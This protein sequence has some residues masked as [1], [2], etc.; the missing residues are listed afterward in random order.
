MGKPIATAVVLGVIGLLFALIG[1]HVF[2]VNHPWVNFSP[3]INIT[4]PTSAKP[5]PSQ[6]DARRQL[7]IKRQQDE[8]L[9]A[10]RRQ[11][12]QARAEA[13]AHRRQLE[14][15][16]AAEEAEA[17]NRR[18]RQAREAEQHERAQRVQAWRNANG[19]CDPPMRKQCMTMG[20]SG[21]GP[22]QVLGCTCVR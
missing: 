2:G 20:S 7:E 13:E 22:R 14:A 5:D 8:R 21:G 10:I 16:R 4:A 3:T 11:E 12:E 6:E 9:A 1:K 18:I 19:G 17:A 15:A